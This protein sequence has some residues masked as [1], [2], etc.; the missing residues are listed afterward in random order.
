MILQQL[1]QEKTIKNYE[2]FLVKYLKDQFI[3]M[4]IQQIVRIKVQK[5]NIDT[6][7]N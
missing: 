5:M 7:L 3:G 4:N 2:N 6:F 1:Y